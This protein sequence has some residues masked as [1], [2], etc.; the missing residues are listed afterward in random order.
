MEDT[1]KIIFAYVGSLVTILVCT[2]Q[3]VLKKVNLLKK[4]LKKALKKVHGQ[5]R[6]ARDFFGFFTRLAGTQ[7]I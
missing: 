2:T 7:G 6:I 3:K 5:A 1:E 4:V